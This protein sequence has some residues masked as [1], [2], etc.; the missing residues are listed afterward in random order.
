MPNFKDGATSVSRHGATPRAALWALAP[1]R[2]GRTLYGA[3]IVK[4]AIVRQNS[5]DIHA[6]DTPPRHANIVGWPDAGVNPQMRKA[7]CKELASAIADA[8][9]FIPIDSTP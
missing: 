2:E 6:D 5:L 4:A 8:A 7:L 1:Q 9:T 3:A